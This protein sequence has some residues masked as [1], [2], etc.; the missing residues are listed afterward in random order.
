MRTMGR[1][2]SAD[3]DQGA[4]K[5]GPT[6]RPSPVRAAEPGGGHSHASPP[7]GQALIALQRSHGNQF[8]QRA[9]VQAKLAVGAPGDRFERE[10][11]RI[12]QAVVRGTAGRLGIQSVGRP[13]GATSG[14]P[15][16]QQG[17]QQA[18]GR[19]QAIPDAVRAPVEQVLGVDLGSVRLHSDGTADRLN[20]GIQA[21]AF[22]SGQD[23]FLRRG[24]ADMTSPA[25]RELIAHEL[26]HV[27]Q[28]GSCAA[29]GVVQRKLWQI[30]PN[31]V[32]DDVLQVSA[33][34]A[35]GRPHVFVGDVDGLD[36]KISG[37]SKGNPKLKLAP[38]TFSVPTAPATWSLAGT[39]LTATQNN[40]AASW[41]PP[42][43]DEHW[44]SPYRTTEYSHSPG[45]TAYEPGL[46]GLG[47]HGSD[48]NRDA[49]GY[50]N[51][52]QFAVAML[53]L[54]QAALVGTPWPSHLKTAKAKKAFMQ[55][56]TLQFQVTSGLHGKTKIITGYKQPSGKSA[57][58]LGHHSHASASATFNSLGHTQPRSD[59]LKWNKTTAAYHGLEDYIWSSTSAQYDPK[60][61][62]PRPDRKSHR[63]YWDSTLPASQY[64]GGPWRSWDRIPDAKLVAYI[65]GKISGVPVAKRDVDHF[66]AQLELDGLKVSFSKST[67]RELLA[68]IKSKGW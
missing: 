37:I 24:Q 29:E 38:A 54:W 51:P 48:S 8:V 32:Y 34:R 52:D 42:A 59:N 44:K 64:T 62:A 56:P 6:A 9:V 40:T 68:M 66:L 13:A 31:R 2:R 63:S 46:P 41:A 53:P 49:A 39:K 67:A 58:V 19:G 47:P 57:V 50:E 28:Q 4:A 5:A 16:L 7:A 27:V 30:D 60:Y 23:I 15:D 35:T 3:L 20:R 33:T 65:E 14:H 11:D 26:T 22:T 45:G 36:Y 55:N 12:A 43:V 18:R 17:I 61:K 25:G 21:R 1:T 10:A